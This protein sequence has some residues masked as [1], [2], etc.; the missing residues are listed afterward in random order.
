[1]QHSDTGFI[2]LDSSF[3]PL[4]ANNQALRILAY[5]TDPVRIQRVDTF[6]GDKLRTGLMVGRGNAAT[7]LQ[8]FRSGRRRYACSAL[9][10]EGHSHANEGALLLLLER[11]VQHFIELSRLAAE[12]DL[13]PRERE[14]VEFLVQGLTTKEI[15]KRMN[16]SPS[17]VSTFLRL[18]MVKMG[19]NSRNGIVGKIVRPPV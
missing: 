5:P 10:L 15:A 9:R 18:V 17:T 7:F 11:P 1:M 2:L 14:A 12:Y 3:K 8:E 19:T 13:T 16:V 4:A 6:L